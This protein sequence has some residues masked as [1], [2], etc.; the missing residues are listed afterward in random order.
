MLTLVSFRMRWTGIYDIK[1]FNKIVHGG[2]GASIYF[3]INY[4]KTGEISC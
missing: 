2:L 4:E 1:N 3:E